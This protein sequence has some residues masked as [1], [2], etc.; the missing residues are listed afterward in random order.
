MPDII[1]SN[2]LSHGV[3]RAA[4]SAIASVTELQDIFQLATR[5]GWGVG[6]LHTALIEGLSGCLRDGDQH[7]SAV[8]Y[9]LAVEHLQRDPDKTLLVSAETGK[10]IAQLPSEAFYVP[11]PAAREGTDELVPQ[12]PRLRP[13]IE[14]AIVQAQFDVEQDKKTLETLSLRARATE[15]VKDEGDRRLLFAT[16][17]GRRKLK[18]QLQEELSLILQDGHGQI[19]EFIR[20]C[21]FEPGAGYQVDGHSLR[22][23]AHV[24]MPIVDSL[25]GN[26]RHDYYS[27]LKSSIRAQWVRVLAG[28]VASFAHA[29]FPVLGT[30]VG[31]GFLICDADTH[32]HIQPRG[33]LPVDNA[34][35]VLVTR[36]PYLKIDPGSYVCEAIER[37]GHWEVAAGLEVELH[38]PLEGLTPYIIPGVPM[39]GLHVEV[40]VRDLSESV[41]RKPTVYDTVIHAEEDEII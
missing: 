7:V 41:A 39:S 24:M 35:T 3:L 17:A 1:P 4:R 29:S 31:E 34:P 25:A 2:P 30:P 9:F 40:I 32:I 13:E 12:E 36:G 21:R 5:E 18:D 27:V 23:Q 6:Q 19:A 37:Y 11:P 14:S 26:L 16:K 15:L 33:S 22:I 10:A 8:A 38:L 28:Q 20:L